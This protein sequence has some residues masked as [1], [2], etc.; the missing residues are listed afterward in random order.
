M[1]KTARGPR[2][3]PGSNPGSSTRDTER[4]TLGR[5]YDVLVLRPGGGYATDTT[6]SLSRCLERVHDL[7]QS[8]RGRRQ[9]TRVINRAT[10]HTVKMSL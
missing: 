9:V 8:T 7:K 10:G 5:M 2:A 6:G 3:H 4:P 1:R